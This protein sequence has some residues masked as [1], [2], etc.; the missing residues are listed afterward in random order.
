MV[1]MAV[2]TAS[3][4]LWELQPSPR[5]TPATTGRT[6]V[7]PHTTGTLIGSLSGRP[8]L[9]GLLGGAV[10]HCRRAAHLEVVRL[11]AGEVF[12]HGG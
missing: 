10:H 2:F 3:T 4:A 1:R 5:F 8:R 11:H 6:A 9:T 12:F 7:F